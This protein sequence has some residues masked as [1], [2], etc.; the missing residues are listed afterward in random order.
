MFDNYSKSLEQ[1]QALPV[2]K[3]ETDSRK[4]A[5]GD[6]F[7]CRQ[8]LTCDSHDFAEDAINRGAI[9]LIT[10]QELEVAVPCVTTP[11]FSVS[12]S[13]INQYYQYP[14]DQL[15]NIGVTGTNGKTTVAYSLQQLLNRQFPTAYTGTLGCQF[16]GF[17]GELINTT[18]DAITLLNLMTRMSRSGITHHIMEVSSHTLDQ[19]RVSIINFDMIIITN[20]GEDHLDYHGNKNEYL[21]AKLRLIDRLKPNGIAVVNLDDPVAPAVIDRCRGK[22]RVVTY[23]SRQNQADYRISNIQSSCH[24]GQFTVENQNRSATVETPL[25]FTFNIENSLAVLAAFDSIQNNLEASAQELSRLKP[26]PGRCEV[27]TLASGATIIIDYAHN[28]DGLENLLRNVRQHTR[29][30]IFTV[31]GVTGDRLPD[32]QA[33]G[34]TSSQLSDVSYFTTDNP[35]GIKPEIIIQKMIK[36]ADYQKYRIELDRSLAIEK[37][38]SQLEAGDVLLVCGKGRERFQYLS[39]DKNAPDVYFGDHNVVRYASEGMTRT[40]S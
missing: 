8:G 11:G 6:I 36:Q 18:P 26:T 13:L 34:S 4:V 5:Y 28:Q 40:L 38:L 19:D 23:G 35:L 17:N 25:P 29:G 1:L 14:Q 21:Q 37:A 31:I 15:F 30:R 33:I 32:A 9:G 20:L 7:V 3:F 27:T 16:D 22:A 12:V 10:N 2:G 39:Q 24:G